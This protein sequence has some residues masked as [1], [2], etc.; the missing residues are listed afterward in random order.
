[1][2]PIALVA[3]RTKITAKGDGPAVDISSFSS[4]VL[5]ATLEIT[6]TVEQESLDVAI[7]GSEDG[8]TWGKPLVSFPQRFYKG[9]TPV[10]LD[11]TTQ[12]EIKILR[13]HWEVN[14]WGRGPEQPM[15][16]I[17]V[18]LHEVPPEVLEEAQRQAARS[19]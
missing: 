6:D 16:E 12:P 10:L 2:T 15:F 9:E 18:S 19:K 1:M 4:R 8:K 17:G 11:L 5:L 3:D 13:A 14:R 7:V